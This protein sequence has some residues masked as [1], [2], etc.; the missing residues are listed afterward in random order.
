MMHLHILDWPTFITTLTSGI[1][2]SVGGLLVRGIGKLNDKLDLINKHTYDIKEIK[3]DVAELK[4]ESEI[5][6]LRMDKLEIS[7]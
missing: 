5:H 2:I 3:E 6:S 4:H 1:I 7:K